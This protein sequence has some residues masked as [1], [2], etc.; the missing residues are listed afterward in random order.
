MWPFH[1]FEFGTPEVTY[2]ILTN[3]CSSFNVSYKHL[4][5]IWA[6]GRFWLSI[7]HT[8]TYT[9]TYIHTLHAFSFSQSTKNVF[10]DEDWTRSSKKMCLNVPPAQNY[11]QC[12]F[13]EK[14]ITTFAWR[15]KRVSWW[16]R[17]FVLTHF[18]PIFDADTFAF[19]WWSVG[20]I[21]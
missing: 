9:H 14:Q 13:M 21:L 15:C 19:L 8:H 12:L 1:I 2:P 17:N 16:C 10:G 4:T 11:F 7:R 18:R 5:N 20:A 6:S 3:G